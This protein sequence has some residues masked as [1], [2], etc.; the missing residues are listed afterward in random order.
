METSSIIEEPTK[1]DTETTSTPIMDVPPTEPQNDDKQP[2]SSKEP[3]NHPDDV[4]MTEPAHTSPENGLTD[5]S[6]II[7]SDEQPTTNPNDFEITDNENAQ[8]NTQTIP[9][10]NKSVERQLTLEDVELLGD[11]DL[12]DKELGA[13]NKSGEDLSIEDFNL[14]ENEL[15][16]LAENL[17][18]DGWDI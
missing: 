18:Q 11:D 3:E 4:E 10:E 14:G 12:P 1:D 17:V 5:P 2:E 9:D 6:S 15:N 13:L 8:D 7:T 16:D